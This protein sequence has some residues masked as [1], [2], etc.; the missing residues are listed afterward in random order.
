[1]SYLHCGALS[2]GVL[3]IGYFF[4]RKK[5]EFGDIMNLVKANLLSKRLHDRF[6]TKYGTCRCADL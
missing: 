1:M 2:G 6:V 3:A 5:K 4:G